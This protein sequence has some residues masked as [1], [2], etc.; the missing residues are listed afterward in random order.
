MSEDNLY[1][2]NGDTFFQDEPTEQKEER[3]ELQSQVRAELPIIDK[4]IK[5]LQE[6][7]DYYGDVNS[8]P[9]ITG[10]SPDA[11]V[12]EARRNAEVRQVLEREKE[13]LETMI[14]I[15]TAED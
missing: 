12:I 1:P 8:L 6:R 10:V 3:E 14:N 2:N 11:Y 4:V 13:D 7:I 9:N 5:H 15:L